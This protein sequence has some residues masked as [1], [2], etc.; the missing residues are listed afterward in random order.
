MG[1]GTAG[2]DWSLGRRPRIHQASFFALSINVLYIFS[3]REREG[4]EGG[5][6]EGREGGRM[7]EGGRESSSSI[8]VTLCQ[9][10]NFD[11]S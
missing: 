4:R 6:E 7:G 10:T 3:E 9:V 5:S 8:V 2:T 1:P 11:I